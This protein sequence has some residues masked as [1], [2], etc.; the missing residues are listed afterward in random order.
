LAGEKLEKKSQR[1]EQR[2]I[3]EKMSTFSRFLDKTLKNTKS[4]FYFLNTGGYNVQL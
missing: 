3:F 4:F 2:I 1:G